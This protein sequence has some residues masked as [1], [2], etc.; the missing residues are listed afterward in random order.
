MPGLWNKVESQNWAKSLYVSRAGCY[1][2]ETEF[3]IWT[4]FGPAG[5][6]ENFCN[7]AKVSHFW[8][9]F[10][11][12]FMDKTSTKLEFLHIV[13]IDFHTCESF[14]EALIHVVYMNCSE[15]Q[16]KKQL[17]YTT[18][19]E[20]VIFIYWTCNSMNNLSHIVG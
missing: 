17:V 3:E 19:S 11:C 13:A 6:T 2:Y 15:C 5:S 1:F 12:I 18:C 4:G 9:C 10:F 20:L 14:S 7:F 8:G 16:N